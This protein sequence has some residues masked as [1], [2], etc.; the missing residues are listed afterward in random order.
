MAKGYWIA[1]VR[2]T[3][4]ERYKDY[5]AANAEAFRKYGAKFVVRGGQS[6]T[7]SGPVHDRHVVLEFESY[8]T[9]KAC[10]NSPEYLRAKAI[11]DEASEADVVI[12]EGFD[13]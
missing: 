3:D 8:A 9:A 13:G 1:R 2:I 5:V 4:P 11:R 12:V 7:P 10:Y 6:E